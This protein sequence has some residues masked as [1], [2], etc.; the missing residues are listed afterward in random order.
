MLKTCGAITFVMLICRTFFF[1][2]RES[3]S[4]LVQANRPL[5]ALVVLQQINDVNGSEFD[6]KI[7]DVGGS[8]AATP[9]KST[10]VSPEGSFMEGRE[11][12]LSPQ[13]KEED[14]DAIEKGVG[15]EKEMPAWLA[16]LP[17]PL[18]ETV[19]MSQERIEELFVPNWRMTTILV[20][21]IWTLV[22][23]GYTI[24]NAFLPSWLERKLGGEGTSSRQES[25]QE[26]VYYTIAGIPGALVGSWIIGTP[27]GQRNSM[28]LCVFA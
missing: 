18:A 3:P 4:W 28:A 1:K 14:V 26:Y 9:R 8:S 6:F 2:L 10:N 17:A 27:L 12:L 13:P 11:P 22:S 15:G 19:S 20:W 24:F 25:L 21:S 5:E 16:R 7:E 23:A